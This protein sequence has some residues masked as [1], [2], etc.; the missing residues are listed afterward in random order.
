ME[1]QS[2]K[3]KTRIVSY[4]TKRSEDFFLL[5]KEELHSE[6]ADRWMTEISKYIP[7]DKPLN[8]LDVGCGAGLFS[9]MLAQHGHKVTGIDLTPDM[10]ACARRMAAE[11][12]VSCH[13]EIMD[14]E[15]LIFK[16]ET[17]DLVISRNL[18]WTLPNAA[19]AYQEWLRVLKKEGVLLN[20]DADYG[21]SDCRET[22]GLPAKH[23]HH[24]IGKEMNEECEKIK[25]MLYIS[26]FRRPAWDMDVLLSLGVEHFTVDAG[27]SE[28]IYTKIDEF[29]NP[30]PMFLLCG[31]KSCE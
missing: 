4:W 2:K 28:R 13:F 21:K 24:T 5:K 6:L 16:D 19:I 26:H 15:Q 9:V 14:A 27:I 12:G 31:K 17:F 10:I 30:D 7:K 22:K 3:E 25:E 29:Y 23:A 8:V 11:E 1:Q 20:F 18:T